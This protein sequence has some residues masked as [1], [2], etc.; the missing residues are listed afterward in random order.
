M[1]TLPFS[2]DKSPNIT[3][4]LPKKLPPISQLKSSSKTGSS[5]VAPV[6][7]IIYLF[8]SF[9]FFCSVDIIF[10]CFFLFLFW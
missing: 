2:D 8:V 9:T 1:Q 5:V 3:P 4:K 7:V 6:N 10:I